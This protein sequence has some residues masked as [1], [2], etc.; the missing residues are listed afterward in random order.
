MRIAVAQHASPKGEASVVI[1]V[2]R[3]AL[4]RGA[5][6]VI[7]PA[8]PVSSVDELSA[9][10]DRVVGESEAVY[11]L[12]VAEH[13]PHGSLSVIESGGMADDVGRIAVLVGDA[14]FDRGAWERARAAE[15]AAAILCPLSESDLQA[16]AAH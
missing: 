8:I 16:E 5:G 13:A 3:G 9:D 15:V 14:C 12:P 6:L 4:E 2:V 11:I 1:P 10:L 7:C